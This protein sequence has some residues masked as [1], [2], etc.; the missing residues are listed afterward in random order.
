MVIASSAGISAVSELSGRSGVYVSEAASCDHEFR[1]F[2]I[3]F[4]LAS[5]MA[6]VPL[7]QVF[8]VVFG[9]PVDLTP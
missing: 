3:Q 6:N 5:Q 7:H 2:R 9:T 8:A 4:D 1:L